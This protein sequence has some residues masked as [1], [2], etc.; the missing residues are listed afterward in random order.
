MM[1]NVEE[2]RWL[3]RKLTDEG[4]LIEAGFVGLRIAA[5]PM[6]APEIQVTEIRNAFFA[7]ALHL[8]ASIMD[9]MDKDREPTENDMKRMDLINKEL[10]AFINDL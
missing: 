7:G 10:Q 6:D 2:L 9:I 3:S 8:F 4:K 1:T 5:I